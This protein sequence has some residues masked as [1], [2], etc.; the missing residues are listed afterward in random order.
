MTDSRNFIFVVVFSEFSTWIPAG[1]PLLPEPTKLEVLSK[2][3]IGPN[4]LRYTIS[5]TGPDRMGL[6][7]SPKFGVKV[8]NISLLEKMPEESA[9]WNNRDLY[10][11]INIWGKEAAPIKFS[12]DVQVPKNVSGVTTEIAVSGIFPHEDKNRKMPH[13]VQFLNEFPDWADLTAWLGSYESW[14]I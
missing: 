8:L 9:V 7:F 12:F 3:Q 6:Y 11:I 1:Q 14:W 13:Y 10:F 4:I 2:A 5:I